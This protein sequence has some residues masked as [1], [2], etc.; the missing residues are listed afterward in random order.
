[1]SFQ[2]EPRRTD[3]SLNATLIG[4]MI[5]FALFVW[6][7][8]RFVWP[9]LEANLKAREQKIAEGLAAAERGHK[10]LELS[11][12]RAIKQLHDAK[13]QAEE[14]IDKARRQA[15]LLLEEARSQ[16]EKEYNQLLAVGIAELE[17][18]RKATREQLI[19]D[20][21][22][23]AI[24]VSEK[25]LGRAVNEADHRRVLDEFVAQIEHKDSVQP[26]ANKKQ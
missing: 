9:L 6:F 26:Q 2:E 12:N 15:V 10:E 23:Q 21:G 11:Q 20:I 25:L 17:Q 1:M 16:G 5:T 4:Q 13:L 18:E 19:K 7:T 22:S 24:L 14:I 8:M 3:V